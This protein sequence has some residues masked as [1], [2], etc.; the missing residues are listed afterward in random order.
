MSSTLYIG[1]R[2]CRKFTQGIK[3]FIKEN[4]KISP[5]HLHVSRKQYVKPQTKSQNGMKYKSGNLKFPF[6]PWQCYI[7]LHKHNNELCYLGHQKHQVRVSQF[8]GKAH[9]KQ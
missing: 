5:N 9:P 4:N 2:V 7:E 1:I 3:N 6:S 8:A